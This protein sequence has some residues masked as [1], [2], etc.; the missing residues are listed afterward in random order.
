MVSLVPAPSGVP[1]LSPALLEALRGACAP[2]DAAFPWIVGEGLSVARE[3]S[4]RCGDVTRLIV[5][6]ISFSATSTEGRSL[7]PPSCMRSA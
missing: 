6:L 2:S 5:A 1:Q 4:R 7:V 3:R